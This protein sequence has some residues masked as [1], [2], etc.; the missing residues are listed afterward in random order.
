MATRYG[1]RRKS[2]L[3]FCYYLMMVRSKQ[4]KIILKGKGKE[5]V[6]DYF[7]FSV[8]SLINYGDYMILLLTSVNCKHL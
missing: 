1:I 4:P 6:L 5:L 7:V 2:F 8:V 3:S